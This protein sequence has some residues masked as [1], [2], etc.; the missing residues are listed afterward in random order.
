M[1]P[2]RFDPSSSSHTIGSQVTD[3]VIVEV[4]LDEVLTD[5]LG[6]T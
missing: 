6:E 4:N 1:K 5:S 3:K 2:V